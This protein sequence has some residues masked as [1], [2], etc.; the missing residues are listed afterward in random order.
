LDKARFASTE[1]VSGNID[2]AIFF[3]ACMVM[4]S[5][6][7]KTTPQPPN[8]NCGALYR[9]LFDPLYHAD[10]NLFFV[11]RPRRLWP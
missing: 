10:K 5:S 6:L 3:S 8:G 7:I 2:R 9:G 4:V 11:A 1:A